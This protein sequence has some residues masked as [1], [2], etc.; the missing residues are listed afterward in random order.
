MAKSSQSS[1]SVADTTSD[2]CSSED[3]QGDS[4]IGIK[5]RIEK[6]Y[7]KLEGVT[8]K[9]VFEKRVEMTQFRLPEPVNRPVYRVVDGDM[10]DLLAQIRQ[11]MEDLEEELEEKYGKESLQAAMTVCIDYGEPKNL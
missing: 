11:K 8:F 2:S 7:N 6:I 9:G 5:E 3:E 4:K 1:Q 10:T